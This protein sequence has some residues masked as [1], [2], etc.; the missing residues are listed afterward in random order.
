M[1]IRD[2]VLADAPAACE[3]LRRSITELCVADH[4][5]DPAAAFLLARCRLAL[6][7]STVP[8]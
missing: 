8:G 1:E 7:R 5:D 3:V 2:A 4:Q 6:S